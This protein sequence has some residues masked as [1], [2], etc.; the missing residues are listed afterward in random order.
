MM[1]IS[2]SGPASAQPLFI[3]ADVQGVLDIRVLLY[4]GNLKRR[5]RDQSWAYLLAGVRVQPAQSVLPADRD[6]RTVIGNVQRERLVTSGADVPTCYQ[7]TRRP[8]W[9]PE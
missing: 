3:G 7:A 1:R 5:V 4:L 9:L 2:A 8:A 6:S